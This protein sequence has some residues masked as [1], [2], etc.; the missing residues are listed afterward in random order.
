MLLI[1]PVFLMANLILA[2]QTKTSF[3]SIT[4][5]IAEKKDLAEVFDLYFK[6]KDALV[7]TDAKSATKA[8]KK[9]EESING[10]EMAKLSMDV[11]M[12][13]ME[14]F[15]AIKEDV[16]KISGAKT[17][18]FQR[19]NFVNLSTNMYKLMK[20]AKYE[21]PVYYQFCPM[22]NEG[23]GAN[24]LS[25]ENKVQNPYYGS[26]MMTCGKVVETIK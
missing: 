22:A 9:L 11:H 7:A 24:W 21:N 2:E 3:I 8:A 23:K 4:T 5:S 15:P 20:V 16:G 25:K 26:E 18:K 1:L 13:W 14:L 19:E 17:I 12:I 6:L 10:V